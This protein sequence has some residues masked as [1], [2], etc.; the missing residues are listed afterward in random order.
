ML[1]T[2]QNTN[3]LQNIIFFSD[4]PYKTKLSQLIT[5]TQDGDTCLIAQWQMIGVFLNTVRAPHL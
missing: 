3:I 1:V 5:K 4:Q 2:E